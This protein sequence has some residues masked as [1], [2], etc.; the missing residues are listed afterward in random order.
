LKDN[1]LVRSR[2]VAFDETVF[3]HMS[4]GNRTSSDFNFDDYF[5]HEVASPSVAP[6]SA[7]SS[8]PAAPVPSP[9]VFPV[10]PAPVVQTSCPSSSLINGNVSE[11]NILSYRQRAPRAFVTSS[12]S[13]TTHYNQAIRSTE[14]SSW[15]DAIKVEL[16]AMDR[17][18]VWTVVNRTPALK[19]V[20]TTRCGKPTLNK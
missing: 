15:L 13:I 14:S 18:S 12:T 10:T 9:I 19:M 7:I 11:A 6:P 2:H 3:P 16:E 8:T 1:K 17:L 4:V 5:I 20:G